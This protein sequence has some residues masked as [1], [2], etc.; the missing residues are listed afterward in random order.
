[1]AD[2]RPWIV[3]AGESLVDRLVRPDGG[4]EEHPGGGPFN[5]ARALGRLGARV[6]F[7][8][9]ISTDDRGHVLRR[10]LEAD[11]V[12]LS[13]MQTIDRPTLVA[14]ATLDSDGVASYRFDPSDSAAAG[15]MAASLPVDTVALHVGT[16]GLVLEPT[17][18]TIAGLVAAAPPGVLVMLDPN[19]RPV[20][21]V[22]E[23]R[24][25][26]RLDAV[27]ARADLVKVSVDDLSWLDSRPEIDVAAGRLVTAGPAAVLVTNGPAPVRV[28]TRAGIASVPVPAVPVVD[29]I[30]AGD[31]FSAGFLAAWTR[32][33]RGRADL[34]DADAIV[35][36]VRSAVRVASWTVGR[37]GADPP[38]P[39]DPAS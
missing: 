19:I 4:V 36:A 26:A 21:I 12:D 34:A 18:A 9:G 5:T 35:E 32:A 15:L 23:A 2:Q 30:G 24:Y 25:R 13:L 6:G 10:T 37:A 28:V 27:L 20:A 3:V 38:A 22:D 17:A 39:D 7:V 29:T 14:T 1:M 11:G 16:L 31:A 33:R 8:G